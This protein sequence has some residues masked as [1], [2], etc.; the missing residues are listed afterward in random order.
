MSGRSFTLITV[1][2]V[3]ALLSLHAEAR[4]AMALGYEPKYPQGFDHFDYVNP[5]APQ[6]GHVTLS[7]FGTFETLNPFLLKTLSAAGLQ[8]LVF[9]TL[10][11]QSRDEPFTMYGLLAEDIELAE[12]RESVT[13]RLNPDARFSNGD[14]VLARDV[15]ASFELLTGE[16]AHPQYRLYWQDVESA[17]VIDERTIRFDFARANPELH[18]I[19]AELPVFSHKWIDGQP[20]DEVTTKRPIASGPYTIESFSQGDSITYKRDPDYWAEDLNVRR[21][22]FNFERV[23]YEYY[24]DFTVAF[25]AFKAGEFDFYHELHSKR[26]AREYH[27]PGFESGRIKRQMLTHKNNA[28]MQGFMFNLRR[29]LFQDHRVRKAINLAF[30]F[31]WANHH[32]FY[33][34]YRRCTSYFSN[35]ELAARDGSPQGEVKAIL[36]KHSEVLPDGVFGPTARPPTTSDETTLRDNLLRARELLH[37]AGW[38]VDEKGVLRNESGE[39]FRFE[40]LLAQ[41]GFERILAPFFRNLE[42]LGMRPEYRTV[43]AALYQQRV[44]SFNFDMAVMSFPQSQSPGNEL[45]SMFHSD[46][47]DRQGSRNYMGI[48]DPGI[49]ALIDEVVYARDRDRLIAAARALDRALLHG[50]YLV[51]NWYIDAHRVAYRD[52]LA[53]PE[54]QPLYYQAEDWMLESWWAEQR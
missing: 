43:D 24:R 15:K 46:N 48:S 54:T 11:V 34:Q 7:A 21:G 37:E 44:R 45:R 28:G 29:P 52:W 40:F 26:W 36:E 22:M 38:R 23:T 14:P 25:E 42:R 47:A 5:D 2:L 30:D 17:T 19:T 8:T 10:M 33:G 51:P 50:S 3:T 35:S 53:M 16:N 20:F 12:D 13:F 39:A 4:Y 18:L 27:G 31:P 32:L 41:E 49:D 1:L 6:G 9:E